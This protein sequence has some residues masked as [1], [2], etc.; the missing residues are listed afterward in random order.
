MPRFIVPAVAL[1]AALSVAAPARAQGALQMELAALA[2]DVK[3]LLDNRQEHDIVMGQFTCSAD[4]PASAGPAIAMTLGNELK[5]Q[6][7]TV[8]LRGAKVK[9]Q[10]T[11][12]DMVDQGTVAVRI[13][14]DFIE[15]ATNKPITKL[16]VSARAVHGEVSVGALLG[17]TVHT[18]T[19]ASDQERDQ[20]LRDA[21]RRPGADLG[22]GKTLI[23]APGSKYALELLVKEGSAYRPRAG[24][25]QDGLAMVPI[26]RHELFEVRVHNDSDAE[27][28]VLLTLDGLNLFTFSQFRGPDGRPRYSHFIV[29]AHSTATIKG[30]HK[31]NDVSSEFLVTEYAKGA[32]NEVPGLQNSANVGT[33][34]ATFSAA[35]PKNAPRPAD[36]PANPNQFARSGDAIGRGA[37][38]AAK[39]EEVERQFGVVRD[40]ISVR[41]QK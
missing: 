25:L 27:A 4:L 9:V 15:S 37:D 2:K 24:H 10:G 26:Q 12:R 8:R 6:G 30:W 40:T 1:L 41:Y 7:I 14:V 20:A 28:A 21:I 16:E 29:A 34:T 17:L 18:P 36:E 32:V 5:S 38:T 23:R 22:P 3:V 31:N 19:G 13:D 35:W 39:M 33:I 11:Y